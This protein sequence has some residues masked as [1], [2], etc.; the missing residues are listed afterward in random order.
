MSNILRY[1]SISPREGLEPGEEIEF[2]DPVGTADTSLPG[3]SEM[4]VHLH[5]ELQ[6]GEKYED[7]MSLVSGD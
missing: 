1:A 5:M 4:G 7:F 6:H 3:E 2:G